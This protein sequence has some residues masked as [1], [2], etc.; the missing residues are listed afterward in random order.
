MVTLPQSPIVLQRPVGSLG[1]SDLF[2]CFMIVALSSLFFLSYFN[3]FAGI[4]SGA[5]EWSG[6]MALLA[7]TLPYRDYYTAGPPLN[8]LKSA[9]ELAL[10]G[11][12]LIVSRSAAVV[13]RIATALLLYAWLRRSFS[14]TA[15][16]L[17][18]IVTIIVSAGDRSD[19]LASYNH[20]AILLAMICGFAACRSLDETA[21]G[22]VVL[23]ATLAGAA[24]SL[25][26]LT[27]QTV[28]LGV[29]ATIFI[30]GF[31]ACWSRRRKLSV[32]WLL[33]YLLGLFFPFL[34]VGGYLHHEG[35]LGAALHMLFITG[36]SAKAA[37]HGAFLR[38][39]VTIGRDNF[40]WVI[41]GVCGLL[42]SGPSLWRGMQ[43]GSAARRPA[44]GTVLRCVFLVGIGLLGGCELLSRSGVPAIWNFSKSAVYYSLFGLSLVGLFLLVQCLGHRGIRCTRAW[45]LLLFTCVGWT[46]AL[47]LSL[48]WPAF[49]AMTLPGFGL[50]L[51]ASVDGV[52]RGRPALYTILAVLVIF[53]VREKLDLPFT[54]GL[55]DERPVREADQASTL[56]ALHGMRL[57]ESSLQF[58]QQTACNVAAE[59]RATDTIFTY[60]EMGLMYALTDRRP[61]TW[62]GSHNIDVIPDEFARQEAARVQA[63]PPAIL[64][65]AQPSETQLRAEEQLWRGGRPSG[66]RAIVSVLNGLA[67][68]YKLLG[69]YVL[70]PGDDPIRVYL[71]PDR[72]GLV[73]TSSVVCRP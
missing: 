9:I 11:K 29:A 59:T 33:S 69:T 8:Q 19:P 58:L 71:R 43:A 70:K 40:P 46:V 54:F 7:G 10:F 67:T 45:E 13:E 4:R 44:S 61:P 2:S 16:T 49:E 23:W 38:R 6:G 32:L 73:S 14:I 26:A 64:I 51:A 52:R 65:Y 27:K 5:G 66:Q 24:A 31:A 63:H 21:K 18:S 15:A 57:P 3:R 20:D 37:E 50:L 36:P 48:S 17:A 53:Q 68:N 34:L 42:L 56:P 25:S 30:L 35:V 28:G 60:P 1:R 12:A 41:L 62:A 55:Q 72:V 39:A 22:H 47:T